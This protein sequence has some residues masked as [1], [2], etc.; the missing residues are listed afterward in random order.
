MELSSGGRTEI[1]VV[2]G[3]MHVLVIK[4]VEKSDQTQYSVSFAPDLSST[5]ALSVTGKPFFL[6][7]WLVVAK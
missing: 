6:V 4:D 3:T 5:A 7:F 2:D 1:S